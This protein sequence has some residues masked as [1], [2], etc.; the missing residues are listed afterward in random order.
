[1]SQLNY[2]EI[3][4]YWK[5]GEIPKPELFSELA[6]KWANSVSSIRGRVNKSSQLRRYY[7]EIL[8]IYNNFKQDRANF[9]L[10]KA[11]LHR[12][13]AFIYYSHGRNLITQEVINLFEGL[14]RDVETPEDFEVVFN[15][16]EAFMAY[17]KYFKR[18]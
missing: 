10:V 7:D 4:T 8:N 15:F 6:Q 5:K 17:Y 18:D 13:I 3:R 2:S 12:I 14:I 16:L 9:E 11:K 1:M